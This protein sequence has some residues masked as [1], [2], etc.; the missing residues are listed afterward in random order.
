MT[1]ATRD[2]T[3]PSFPMLAI[4]GMLVGFVVR[5]RRAASS[6]C[7][8]R[9]SARSTPSAE[10][11]FLGVISKVVQQLAGRHRRAGHRRH[12]GVFVVMLVL[13]KSRIIKVTD[14]FRRIVIMATLG[15]MVFYL[16]LVRHPPVRRHGAVPRVAQHLWASASA[17]SPPA[18]PR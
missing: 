15:L 2:A 7:S 10:G 12:A 5:H 11:F 18:W 16:V 13:Y 9:C 8:P 14:R 3:D 4:A 6:R 17:C 1:A